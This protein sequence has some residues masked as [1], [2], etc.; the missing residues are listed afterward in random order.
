MK[1]K[2]VLLALSLSLVACSEDETSPATTNDDSGF[3]GEVE[4]PITTR[5]D[6]GVDTTVADTTASDVAT[7]TT[8]ADTAASDTR[9]DADALPDVV[10]DV[11]AGITIVTV[12]AGGPSFS[13]AM[14]NIKV[15]ETVR[16]VFTTAGHNVVSGTSCTADNTFCNPSDTSCASAPTASAGT[17]YE[18]TFTTA[19]TFPYFCKPHCTGGMVGSVVVS[20]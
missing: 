9:A 11:G 18:H 7:D 5:P 14:V 2:L 3:D 10:G 6:D 1:L 16:W 4:G 17:N 20:P 15:G 13:P 19:G 8:V 12:G